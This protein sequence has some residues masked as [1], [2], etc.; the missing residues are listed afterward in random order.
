M[1]FNSFDLN[2]DGKT[3]EFEQ[4]MEYRLVTGDFPEKEDESASDFDWLSWRM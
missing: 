3:D 4:M 2:F 1:P